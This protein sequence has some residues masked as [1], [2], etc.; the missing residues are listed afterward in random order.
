[1]TWTSPPNSSPPPPAHPPIF[2]QLVLCSQGSQQRELWGHRTGD[3]FARMRP[4]FI[5]PWR[6]PQSVFEDLELLV[7]D[8]RKICKAFSMHTLPGI[9]MTEL[10]QSVVALSLS[11]FLPPPPFSPPPPLSLTLSVSLSSLPPSLSLFT[12]TRARTRAHIP[13]RTHHIHTVANHHILSD[14][15]KIVFRQLCYSN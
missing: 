12:N 8:C 9:F 14:S 2:F 6:C 4:L 7:T 15:V 10:W 1:M 3:I 13:T 5:W 11:L